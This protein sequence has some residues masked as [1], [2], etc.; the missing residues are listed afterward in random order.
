MNKKYLGLALL[1][2]CSCKSYQYAMSD[3][4][5]NNISEVSD[6]YT[7]LVNDLTLGNMGYSIM[8]YNRGKLS[9]VCVKDF[10]NSGVN[11]KYIFASGQDTVPECNEKKYLVDISINSDSNFKYSAG[12][13]GVGVLAL[14]I[15]SLGTFSFTGLPV[16]DW[17]G[18]CTV[19]AKIRDANNLVLRKI[20]TKGY[21]TANYQMYTGY[22]T[23]VAQHKVWNESQQMALNNLMTELKKIPTSELKKLSAQKKQELVKQYGSST[24]NHILATGKKEIR[25][26]L[27]QEI[28]IGMSED[29][30]T[31]SLGK[32]QDINTT[33]GSFGIHKQF[34]YGL[35]KYVYT[36]D[37]KVTSWQY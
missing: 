5:K 10:N 21:D 34:V 12:G 2:L 33:T 16:G 20:T 37:G 4:Y 15:L 28:F 6:N 13:L 1:L 35:D 25:A 19:T 30:L 17:Y 27:N 7:L 23:D 9:G 24:A 14:D 11:C 3:D 36:E 32:P 22:S 8:N 26:I 31:A 18:D 29:A